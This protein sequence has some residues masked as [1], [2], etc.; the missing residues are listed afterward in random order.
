M[1]LDSVLSLHK[2]NQKSLFLDNVEDLLADSA[3]HTCKSWKHFCWLYKCIPS[4]NTNITKKTLNELWP[5]A[6][7]KD[8]TINFNPDHY[9]D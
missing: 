2:K 9:P 4:Y 6:L 1:S 7:T 3:V 5:V 8:K